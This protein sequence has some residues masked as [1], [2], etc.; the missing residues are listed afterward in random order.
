MNIPQQVYQYFNEHKHQG[1]VYAEYK[2]RL[3]RRPVRI[4]IT[5]IEVPDN[6]WNRSILFFKFPQTNEE[7]S[8]RYQPYRDRLHGVFRIGERGFIHFPFLR[9]F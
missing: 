5:Y 3:W 8:A 4:E 7:H 2:A 6:D 1:P 9:P